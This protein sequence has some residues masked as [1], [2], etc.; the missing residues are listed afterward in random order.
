M[1][2]P[3]EKLIECYYILLKEQD[4]VPPPDTGAT[5]AEA[6]PPAEAPPFQ[7]P[8]SGNKSSSQGYA[9]MVDTIFQ[10]LKYKTENI[11]QKYYNLSDNEISDSNSAYR[12]M[13][14]LTKLLPQNTISDLKNDDLGEEKEGVIPLDDSTMV[15]MANIA[16]NSLF[17]SDKNNF[18]F[19]SK[20]E[21]IQ[22]MLSNTG[23]T[24]TVDNA[25][26]IYQEIKSFVSMEQ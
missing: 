13:T 2:I 5:G 17:Y 15:E 7:Q 3:F 16:I 1:K 19:S 12:Y 18:E 20:I 25:N 9:H 10:L 26:A 23:N 21:D 14:V 22:N 11:P 8:E 6:P 24:V 4:I